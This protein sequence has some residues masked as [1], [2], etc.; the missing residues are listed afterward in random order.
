[1][2][3]PSSAGMR[4]SSRRLGTWALQIIVAAAF[5]AAATAKFAGVPFMTHV[6]DQIGLGQWLRIVTGVLEIVG[7][8]AL[9]YPGTAALGGLWLGFAMLCAMVICV[10]VLHS[11]PAPAA[12]LLALNA[13]IVYLRRDELVTLAINLRSGKL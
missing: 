10:F 13:L 2:S 6:F 5:F 9:L 8:L 12:V 4:G 3:V 11:S 1:M 7:V